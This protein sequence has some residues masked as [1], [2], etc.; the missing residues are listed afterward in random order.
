MPAVK[1]GEVVRQLTASDRFL[2]NV[3]GLP[4]FPKIER[5]QFEKLRAMIMDAMFE[6]EQSAKVAEVI[7]QLKVLAT[8]RK[9]ALLQC[10][11]DCCIECKP[12]QQVKRG[13]TGPPPDAQDYSY[14]HRYLPA[15]VWED[16]DGQVIDRL[17]ALCRFAAKMGPFCPTEK[18][19]G[20]LTVLLFWNE[21]RQVTLASVEKY[22]TYHTYRSDIRS[23]LKEYQS[24]AK[25]ELRLSELPK[26]FY[27]LP[28]S[29]KKLF[30]EEC[31]KWIQS[32]VFGFFPLSYKSGVHILIDQYFALTIF[33]PI[34]N[35]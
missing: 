16:M 31:L 32:S 4:S 25:E 19:V 34:W 26:F 17:H 9:E 28:D 20:T 22:K 1:T 29:H 33:K 11:A 35:E 10:L 3:K 7:V 24:Y 27:E 6:E 21:W 30:G 23:I 15:N 14:L 12:V 13:T 5:Q 2:A 18:T 8:K